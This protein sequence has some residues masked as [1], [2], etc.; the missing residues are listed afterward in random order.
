[1]SNSKFQKRN[2]CQYC[3]TNLDATYRNKRFC[4]DKCRVYWNREQKLN[5]NGIIP[6]VESIEL[7]SDYNLPQKTEQPK[8]NRIEQMIWEEE[9]IILSQSKK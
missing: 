1:M 9:Q 6:L 7:K 8:R 4:S 2:K 3:E 5:K